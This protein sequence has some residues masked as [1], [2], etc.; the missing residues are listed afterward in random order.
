MGIETVDHVV[1]VDEA[2][3]VVVGVDVDEERGIVVVGI[4]VEGVEGVIVI[5]VVGY[6]EEHLDD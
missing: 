4:E 5:I 1:V 6:K 2:W 3:I